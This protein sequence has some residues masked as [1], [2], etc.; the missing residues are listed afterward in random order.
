MKKVIFDTRE[1]DARSDENSLYLFGY[2]TVNDEEFSDDGFTDRNSDI[3]NELVF[4]K[5]LDLLGIEK[6]RD[7]LWD[8]PEKIQ[9]TISEDTHI[10]EIQGVFEITG[11]CLADLKIVEIQDP[12]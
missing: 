6:N 1:H 11:T 7:N 4:P 8:I 3:L 10:S 12:A 2:Y 5:I 9:D